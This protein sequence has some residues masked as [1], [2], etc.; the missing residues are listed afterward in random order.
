MVVGAVL[1]DCPYLAKQPLDKWEWAIVWSGPEIKLANPFDQV[2]PDKVRKT[3]EWI[4]IREMKL[5][6]SMDINNG[7][8]LIIKSPNT[9]FLA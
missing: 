1:A 3:Y 7:P 6:D 9:L 2:I 5:L 8:Y 4:R